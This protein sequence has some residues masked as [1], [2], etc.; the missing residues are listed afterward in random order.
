MIYFPEWK[1]TSLWQ[2]HHTVR[3]Q[4]QVQKKGEGKSF[5]L[6]RTMHMYK[7]LRQCSYLSSTR[8]CSNTYRIVLCEYELLSH[9]FLHDCWVPTA[10]SLATWDGPSPYMCTH[11]HHH[12]R[13]QTIHQLY[14]QNRTC[15]QLAGQIQSYCNPIGPFQQISSAQ[16][17]YG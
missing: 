17:L 14:V 3:G 10:C 1:Y 12:D 6:L 2:D 9:K 13:V 8:L 4:A 15:S 16:K 11:F 7:E 5:T